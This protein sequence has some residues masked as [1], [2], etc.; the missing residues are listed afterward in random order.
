VK[1]KVGKMEFEAEECRIRE[2]YSIRETELGDSETC[3]WRLPEDIYYEYSKQAAWSRALQLG[4]FNDLSNVQALDV[5][6][7]RGRWLRLLLEWG[8]VPDNLHGIDLF[9]SRIDHAQSISHPF[10]DLRVASAFNL[11]FENESMDVVAATM[12]FSSMPDSEKREWT[13]REMQRLVC[14]GGW[15]MIMDFALSKPSNPDT[16]GITRKEITRLF[17]GMILQHTLN[18]IL[19]PPVVR[20]LSPRFVCI[21]PAIETLMPFLQTHRLFLLSK[22]EIPGQDVSFSQ[23]PLPNSCA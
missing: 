9:E 22:T 15:V 23:N 21:A 6:C 3:P 4:G 8:A 7:G 5:G 2:I 13:A 12:L 11:P 19:A 14:H 17:P 18:L 20:M 16:I 1:E 10:V